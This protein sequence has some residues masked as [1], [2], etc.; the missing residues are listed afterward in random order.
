MNRASPRRD[1]LLHES[2][3]CLVPGCPRKPFRMGYCKPHQL[4][5]RRR[6]NDWPRPGEA[7]PAWLTKPLKGPRSSVV[8]LARDLARAGKVVGS[9]ARDPEPPVVRTDP[10]DE[11]LDAA[12]ALFGTPDS[13][14]QHVDRSMAMEKLEAALRRG[15][16]LA[17]KP[18]VLVSKNVGTVNLKGKR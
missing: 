2:T 7:L 17:P 6:G 13:K 3:D 11:A 10:R 18:E 12:E 16:R 9:P 14:D 8:A 15:G 1:P 5:I 4:R